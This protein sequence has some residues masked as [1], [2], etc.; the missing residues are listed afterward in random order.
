MATPSLVALGSLENSTPPPV[1]KTK[2]PTVLQRMTTLTGGDRALLVTWK[3]SL[4]WV[5]E[6]A[7]DHVVHIMEE[8][9]ERE[10]GLFA[11]YSLDRARSYDDET[12]IEM[13]NWF[14]FAQMQYAAFL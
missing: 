6:R 2:P 5:K 8:G 13:M 12:F 1:A 3:S 4:R 10:R 9:H 14:Y 7:S 11:E